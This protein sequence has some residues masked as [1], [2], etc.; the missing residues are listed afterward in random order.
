[1]CKIFAAD[2]GSCSKLLL[3]VKTNASSPNLVAPLLRTRLQL[4]LRS[5]RGFNS[6]SIGHTAVT[7][8]KS[9]GSRS[10][11]NMHSISRGSS[12]CSNART[13]LTPAQP[14]RNR[15]TSQHRYGGFPSL[16]Q[17]ENVR[18]CS[19]RKE[20]WTQISTLTLGSESTSTASWT[21]WTRMPQRFRKHQDVKPEER[22]VFRRLLSQAFA[23]G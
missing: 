6:F 19:N 1:M 4:K 12:I 20:S 21:K 23:A 16:L 10:R 5:H 11:N 17:I 13:R 18:R 15:M 22:I 7:P 3:L 8:V 2:F 14:T 9:F